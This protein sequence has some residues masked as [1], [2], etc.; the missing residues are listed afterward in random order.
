MKAP[1]RNQ[2]VI[3]FCTADNTVVEARLN[4]AVPFRVTWQESY[5]LPE[6]I[7]AQTLEAFALARNPHRHALAAAPLQSLT[8]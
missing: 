7:L 8:R 2:L 5:T 6:T 1:K 4:S 3:A